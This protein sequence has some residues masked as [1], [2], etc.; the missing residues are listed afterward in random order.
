MKVKGNVFTVN[1][2][3]LLDIDVMTKHSVSPMK[4]DVSRL[5]ID[6]VNFLM[7]ELYDGDGDILPQ[8]TKVFSTQ[9]EL[10]LWVKDNV[11]MEQD[12]FDEF[13]FWFVLDT[14]HLFPD[15]EADKSIDKMLRGKG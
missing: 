2:E 11:G 15:E 8:F 1:G 5:D 12:S 13:C 7:T 9:K 14:K 6:G 4:I 10:L 3:V